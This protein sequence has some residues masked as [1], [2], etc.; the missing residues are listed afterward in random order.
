VNVGD[1]QDGSSS[2]GGRTAGPVLGLAVIYVV[3]GSTYLAIR[4]GV[5]TIPPFLMAGVRFVV[6]GLVLLFW[7]RV[8]G[9][10]WPT[11]SHWRVS[12]ATGA[13]LLLCGNGIVVWAERY[14]A[15]GL[16]ALL[17]TT[18]PLWMVLFNWLRPGGERPP[19]ATWLG[20]FTGFA[21][22]AGLAVAGQR[23]E[24][25]AIDAFGVA[26]LAFASVAWALGSVIAKHAPRP[27]SP[28]L[29]TALQML[30]G[31][32]MLLIASAIAG[33]WSRFNVSEVTLRSFLGFI[34]LFVVGSLLTMP[35]YTWLL[36]VTE[37]ALVST[38]SFVNPVIAVLLGWL[39]LDESLTQWT[40]LAGAVIVAAVA[41][42]IAVQ[43][44]LSRSTRAIRRRRRRREPV[45]LGAT[46]ASER[47]NGAAAR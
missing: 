15:S 13:L 20:M 35:V 6:A 5:E 2:A 36:H 42:L 43:W 40:L 24:T 11:R 26:A 19:G 33:E 23:G 27:E 8:R 34:Y 41:W 1:S 39:F 38:Y 45:Q 44:R 21:G 32:V 29:A 9:A 25:Q 12:L 46:A 14:V 30:S 22:M 31:G 47:E 37:P 18:T 28:F 3:W 16:V 10:P 4:L 7:A 17:L